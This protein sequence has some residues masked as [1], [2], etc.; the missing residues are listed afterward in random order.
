MNYFHIEIDLPFIFGGLESYLLVDLICK[1]KYYESKN[2][3]VLINTKN[4]FFYTY[5]SIQKKLRK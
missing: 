5:E 2:E 4:C 1:Y 3:L